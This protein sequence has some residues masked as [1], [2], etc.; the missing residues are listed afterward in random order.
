MLCNWAWLSCLVTTHEHGCVCFD[1]GAVSQSSGV[2]VQQQPRQRCAVAH[3]RPGPHARR[4]NAHDVH[5]KFS[6]G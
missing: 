6:T 3:R 5:E 2:R 4:D 1:P